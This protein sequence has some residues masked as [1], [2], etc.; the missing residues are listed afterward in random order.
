MLSWLK[1]RKSAN[2]GYFRQTS[3]KLVPILDLINWL[4]IGSY[5]QLVGPTGRD[6]CVQ[7]AEVC[8]GRIHLNPCGSHLLNYKVRHAV[9]TTITT[10]IFIISFDDNCQFDRV[11]EVVLVLVVC[12]PFLPAFTYQL[13]PLTTHELLLRGPHHR[14]L[15]I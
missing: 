8:I 12:H 7:R 1:A 3:A 14:Q 6:G 9:A 4:P 5:F 13:M 11:F 2:V 15:V 10:I